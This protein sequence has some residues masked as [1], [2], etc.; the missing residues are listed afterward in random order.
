MP[1]SRSQGR[2]KPGR[3][4]DSNPKAKPE[5]EA[6]GATRSL[7]RRR[8]RNRR[9]SRETGNTG[10]GGAEGR[11]IRGNSKVR[12]RHSRKVQ[13]PGDRRMH[14]QASLGRAQSRGILAADAP[15]TLK[16]T[17]FGATRSSIAGTAGRCKNWGQLQ[18]C[19]KRRNGRNR[20]AGKPEPQKPPGALIGCG[21]RGD[22]KAPSPAEPEGVVCG[23]ARG[24]V[25]RRNRKGE[26]GGDSKSSAGGVRR[27]RGSGQLE[28]PSRARDLELLEPGRPGDGTKA[29]RVNAW[30][31]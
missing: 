6:R 3:P 18:G 15:A 12:R 10:N 17:R 26:A 13:E 19:I 9:S 1:I 27:M 29:E 4:G 31:K 5:D 2:E 8:S 20:V 16:D 14:R 30:S 28:S 24:R 22:S 23:A 25:E 21:I 7:I 11:A